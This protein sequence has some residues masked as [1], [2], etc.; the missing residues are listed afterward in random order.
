MAS[1]CF[2]F[3]VHQPYRLGRFTFF[4]SQNNYFDDQKNGDIMRKVAY[5]CYLPMNGLLL[6]LIN[7]HNGAFKV[8]FA[9]TGVAVDQMKSY[10]PEA[11]DSFKRLVD[12]GCVE[13]L[14]ETYYHS[15]AAIYSQEEFCEQVAKHKALMKSEFGYDVKIFR[16]TELIYE[17]WI[18]HIVEDLG[19][20][21]MIAEGCDDVLGWRSP[22]YVYKN[23]DLPLL[24]KNYRL[25]DDIAFRFSNQAWEAFPLRAEQ[26]CDWLRSNQG[27]TINLFMDYETFGEHQW[28]STGIFQFMEHLPNFAL[29][30]T[31]FKTPHEVISSC[32]PI[33]DIHFHRLTSWADVDRDLTAW[34]GNRMQE[35]ALKQIY[36]LEKSVKLTEDDALIEDWRKL[37]T[38]DHFYYMC[39]K[40]SN[41][42]DVHA[43]FS[44]FNSPYEAFINFMNVLRHF[45]ERVAEARPS[46]LASRLERIIADN[47]N[48]LVIEEPSRI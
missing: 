5:K 34:R 37:L 17:D 16:N 32:A 38:S 46:K 27:D 6:D 41:D 13:L 36:E 25:S 11:L 18:G 20:E 39:T 42:G 23:R 1:I 45:K 9:I 14:G 43:Y 24:L 29:N 10:C 8:S 15:L 3:Q 40:W 12:T 35:S 33:S 44:P 31:D 19:F 30:F 7:R 2:Y 4:D 26:Y 22:N 21:G 47:H 28:E 48:P